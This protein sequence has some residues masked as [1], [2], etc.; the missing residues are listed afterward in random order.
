[1][2]GWKVTESAYH[3]ELEFIE[4]DGIFDEKM[5]AVK[6]MR[7]VSEGSLYASR[8][9]AMQRLNDILSGCSSIE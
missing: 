2:M 8:I 1:M 9:C 5:E 4:F 6:L 7:L 3:D